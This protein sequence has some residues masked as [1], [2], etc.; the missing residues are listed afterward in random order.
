M[1]VL[2]TGG[3]GFIGSHLLDRLAEGGHKISVIDNLSTGTRA[4]VPARV[5]LHAFSVEAASAVA[6][7]IAVER[8]EVIYHLAAQTSVR[9]SVADPIRDATSNVMGTLAILEAAKEIDAQV[10]MASTSGAMYGDGVLQPTPETEL[11]RTTAPYGISKYCAEQYLW[12]FNRLHGCRHIALRLGNVYGPRQDPYGES[13]VVAIFCRQVAQGEKPTVYGDGAQS[14]DYV[15]VRDVVGAF[16]AAT[17]YRGSDTVFNIGTGHG[18]SVLEVLNAVNSAAGTTLVP[19]HAPARSGEERHAVLDSSRAA[20]QLGWIAQTRLRV[21][22]H[23]TFHVDHGISD[24][25][26][27]PL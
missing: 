8:P 7:V 13:G 15:Y 2:V 6:E 11:P 16:I 14:R 19:I 12:L 23:E 10:I 4:R 1:R 26:S 27:V 9:R 20:K 18:S 17:A 22:I 5:Q 3:A 25:S 24:S 21:G